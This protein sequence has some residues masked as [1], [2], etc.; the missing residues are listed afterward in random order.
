M[1]I[2]E[3]ELHQFDKIINFLDIELPFNIDLDSNIVVY[4]MELVTDKLF[5]HTKDIVYNNNPNLFWKLKYFIVNKKGFKREGIIALKTE[6]DL[7]KTIS[8]KDFVKNIKNYELSINSQMFSK[9]YIVYVSD[10]L[11]NKITNLEPVKKTIE[12][13]RKFVAFTNNP[14]IIS[15]LEKQIIQIYSKNITKSN[16]DISKVENYLINFYKDNIIHY[17]KFIKQTEQQLSKLN[18]YN[19][20]AEFGSVNTH[21]LPEIKSNIISIKIEIDDLEF[22]ISNVSA[23][24]HKK[25]INK[26]STI[27]DLTNGKYSFA[28]VYKLLKFIEINF[29]DDFEPSKQDEDL[30]SL[31][32]LQELK[33]YF[34]KYI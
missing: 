16:E 23:I 29:E 12:I 15:N 33:K 8:K 11:N 9:P 32:K 31:E 26:I 2:L 20:L 21:K 27:Y 10:E 28:D 17:E 1:K 34:K 7:P 30:N 13:G 18:Y 19:I 25:S 24:T 6:N 3:C 5:I 14:N 4:S 22:F